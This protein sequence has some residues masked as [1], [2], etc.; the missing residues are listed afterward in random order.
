MASLSFLRSSYETFGLEQNF[1]KDKQIHD[2]GLV[3]V[4]K[5]IHDDLDAAV[6]DA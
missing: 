5:K 4:L 1:A 2:D 6:F 3:S